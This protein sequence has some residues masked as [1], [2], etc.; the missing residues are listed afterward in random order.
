MIYELINYSSTSHVEE[1]FPLWGQDT[2][3]SLEMLSE[4]KLL[5]AE[6]TMT[7]RG[8]GYDI[9]GYDIQGPGVGW[10]FFF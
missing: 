5:P 8:M 9:Q 4:G 7:S 3:G 1:D 6:G 10:A 2:L